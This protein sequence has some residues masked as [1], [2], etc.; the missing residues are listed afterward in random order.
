MVLS[1]VKE[2]AEKYRSEFEEVYDK[3]FTYS[4]D[5]SKVV[6]E[7][8]QHAN[9]NIQTIKTQAI[10]KGNEMVKTIQNM[11]MCFLCT[12]NLPIRIC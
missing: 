2:L 5:L 8:L 4:S 11:V 10:A 6:Q 3:S 7:Q 1:L 9:E 12:F